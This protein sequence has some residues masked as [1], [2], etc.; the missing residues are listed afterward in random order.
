MKRNIYQLGSK[1]AAPSH[2]STTVLAR[3]TVPVPAQ[4]TSYKELLWLLITSGQYRY[5]PGTSS[6]EHLPGLRPLS[7]YQA[8]PKAILFQCSN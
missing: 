4:P 1:N 2:V 7:M 8:S 5:S 3:P 6:K